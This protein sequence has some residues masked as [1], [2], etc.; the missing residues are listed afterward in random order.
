[1]QV[2]LF[3]LKVH[4]PTEPLVNKI[5]VTGT[6]D[7]REGGMKDGRNEL[8]PCSNVK[9]GMHHEDTCPTSTPGG[10]FDFKATSSFQLPLNLYPFSYIATTSLS[11]PI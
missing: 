8:T 7:T 5:G 2:P 11:S 4:V 3:Q 6:R 9:L 10:T 1:M